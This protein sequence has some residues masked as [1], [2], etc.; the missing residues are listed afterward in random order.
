MIYA[1]VGSIIELKV[2]TKRSAFVWAYTLASHWSATY[3]SDQ[4][5]RSESMIRSDQ[6]AHKIGSAVEKMIIKTT[7]SFVCILE[8]KYFYLGS[9]YP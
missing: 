4:N 8:K 3:I 9:D 6:N 2:Y 7:L 1:S 5:H